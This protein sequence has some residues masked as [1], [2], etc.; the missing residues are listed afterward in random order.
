MFNS[1]TLFGYSDIRIPK[2]DILQI[3]SDS[4]LLSLKIVVETKF[5]NL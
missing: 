5:G 1:K 4:H 2:W 3:L